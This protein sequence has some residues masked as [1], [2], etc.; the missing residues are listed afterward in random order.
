[1]TRKGRACPATSRLDASSVFTCAARCHAAEANG[2]VSRARTSTKRGACVA[3][4]RCFF[5]HA[6][7]GA[8][9]RVSVVAPDLPR[10]NIWLEG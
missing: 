10:T 9:S 8:G 3:E 7:I 2:S 6:K 1:V 5:L 4:N